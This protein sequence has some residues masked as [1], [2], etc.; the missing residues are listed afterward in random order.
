[1]LLFSL[2][3]SLPSSASISHIEVKKEVLAS[4]KS[5]VEAS[6]KLDSKAYF[7]HFDKDKFI[8]LNSNGE[9]WNSLQDLEPLIMNGF[10]SIKKVRLLT[11][12]NVTVSVLNEQT[13]ILVNEYVQS[14]EL[15]NG[16]I[17]ELAG[18]GTQVWFKQSGFWKIVSVSASNKP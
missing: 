15:K 2:V 12:T 13:A 7:A 16:K 1:M 10:G 5:L 4:F 14:I 8:G 9:N 17:V 18:G 6:I 11:F 3:A